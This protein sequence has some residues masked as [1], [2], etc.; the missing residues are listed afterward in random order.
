[1]TVESGAPGTP[2]RYRRPIFWLCMFGIGLGIVRALL[3]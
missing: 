1:M 3:T 2:T